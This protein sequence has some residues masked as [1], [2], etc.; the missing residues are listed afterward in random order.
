MKNYRISIK[1]ARNNRGLVLSPSAGDYQLVVSATS[2]L[3]GQNN[4]NS[5]ISSSL[6]FADPTITSNVNGVSSGK[7]Q[8]LQ[9]FPNSSSQKLSLSK[10]STLTISD[11][12]YFGNLDYE[13]NSRDIHLEIPKQN[14][15]PDK[16]QTKI[17]WQLT[18]SIN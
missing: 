12:P 2:S 14:I 1:D 6:F 17:T 7:P 4:S 18:N 3:T 5:K 8:Q 13:W 15:K 10:N 11:N 9:T 16:Y